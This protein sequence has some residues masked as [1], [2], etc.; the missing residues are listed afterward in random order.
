MQRLLRRSL[1][2]LFGALLPLS[3]WAQEELRVLSD[4]PYYADAPNAAYRYLSEQAFQ[5]LQQRADNVGRLQT[6]AQW[7]EHQEE[8]Q[9][10]LID[11][12][13]PFPEKT[14]LNAR[15][16][17]T[18][19]REGYHV[20]KLLY[21][22]VPGYY[23][24]AALFVP[25]KREEKAPAVL[26]LSG[27]TAEGFRAE[28]YQHV[29]INLVRKGF[30]VLAIDPVGQ[31]ERRQYVDPATGESTMS[32]STKEHSY[33]GAQAFIAGSSLARYM[34]WDGI[35]GIDYLV[36][37]D[38]VDPERIGATG[39]SGGG[40]QTAY[41]AAFDERVR[42]AAPENYI[43]SLHRLFETR[44]PQDAEQNLY[45]GIARGVDHADLLTA[46]APKP[47]LMIATTRDFFSIQGA[48]ETYQEVA[49]AYQAL[50]KPE[51][52]E[53]VEDD[54]EHASTRKNREALYAFFQKHLG[55]PGSAEDEEV[56]LFAPEELQVT[57][58]GQV[59]TSL[60]GETVFSLNKAET[61]QL[62]ASLEQSRKNLPAHL[63]SAVRAARAR[64]G[65]QAPSQ[66]PEAV[67]SGRY[68]RDGYAV[69]KYAFQG[70]GG[71]AVPLLLMVPE[72][73]GPHPAVIYLHPDGKAADAAPGGKMERLVKQGYV[74]LA[75]DL[76]NTGELGGGAYRG[77]SMIGDVSYGLWFGSV[78]TGR[79][80]AGIRAADVVQA[81]RF[82]ARL[83]D[84]TSDTVAVVAYGATSPV[85][86]H[87][88][89]FDSAITEVALIGP[90]LSYYSI[91]TNKD[92]K[93]DFIPN[94]VAGA[95]TSYDL[96]DLAAS[97]APRRLLVV[98]PVDGTGRRAG[99]ERVES[100][101]AMVH[102]AYAA[103]GASEKL[104]VETL[105]ERTSW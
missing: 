20:E 53:M 92:Y 101:L 13:G 94:A 78:L 86:L 37:R 5:Q 2:L 17:G 44:G 63:R 74:V 88:A 105:S 7:Q 12:V 80:L 3:A 35:R 30:V 77:D 32:G 64:S 100:D 62:A 84:V 16:V 96:P 4:W 70:E 23:V 29:I 57:A 89:A 21:E 85:A 102:A 95:L 41:I 79:S 10:T 18:V 49:R 34:T 58:S 81:A 40:T 8:V 38:E 55:L 104:K 1:L 50:G 66:A 47:V 52:I 36:S 48:R 26:Y 25:E 87:A 75:P 69:E 43:T 98:N 28:T 19:E 61:Q 22:S 45:H 76:L 65:Y 51:N 90:P 60:G 72:A 31:G 33:V 59:L 93:A 103:K 73:E 15:V 27:H 83:P 56:E 99:S 9:E 42:A 24:T 71:Y 68:Q 11:I 67:F 46:R 39:R 54:D 97:L 6:A 91:A 14:P 82:L